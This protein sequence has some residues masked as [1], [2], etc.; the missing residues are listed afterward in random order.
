MQKYVD[1]IVAL[2]KQP[3]MDH[4]IEPEIAGEYTTNR[5][6]FEQTAKRWTQEHAH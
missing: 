5:E 3:Q 2:L 4:V 6:Q 1:G